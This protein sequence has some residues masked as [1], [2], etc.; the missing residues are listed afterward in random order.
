MTSW[1]DSVPQHVQ[2]DL[3]LLEMG[4]LGWARSMQA[5]RG[6][7]NPFATFLSHPPRGDGTLLPGDMAKED[8]A[9]ADAAN[10][11]FEKFRQERDRL[12]AVA[13][14]VDVMFSGAPVVLVHLEH[15]E[16]YAFAVFLPYR[17]NPSGEGFEYDNQRKAIVD[18]LIWA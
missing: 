15:R 9:A 8:P 7:F 5:T 13:V 12:R 1:R 16:G 11:L 4:M 17:K 18:K 6:W 14:G 3:D 2:D 10:R